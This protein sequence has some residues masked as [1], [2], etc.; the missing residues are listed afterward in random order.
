MLQVRLMDQAGEMIGL[1]EIRNNGVLADAGDESE[2]GQYEF[3]LFKKSADDAGGVTA[4][5]IPK[6]ERRRGAWALVAECLASARV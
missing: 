5:R 2:F 1:L 4:G 3:T 6:F